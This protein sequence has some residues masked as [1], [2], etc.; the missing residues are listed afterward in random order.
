MRYCLLAILFLFAGCSVSKDGEL[1]EVGDYIPPGEPGYDSAPSDHVVMVRSNEIVSCQGQVVTIGDNTFITA[2]DLGVELEA[3]FRYSHPDEILEIT[4][5][6]DTFDGSPVEL[7]TIAFHVQG[8]N[9]T[10]EVSPL[11]TISKAY[12]DYQQLTNQIQGQ[13][14][15]Y[16]QNSVEAVYNFFGL[17]STSRDYLTYD[18]PV[19]SISND[20]YID[21]INDAFLSLPEYFGFSS[22]GDIQKFIDQ[23]QMDIG[24]DGRFDGF[25][26]DSNL[27]KTQL[28]I[29]GQSS[30]IDAYTYLTDILRVASRNA[31]SFVSDQN[32][33]VEIFNDFSE[34][35]NTRTLL[36][37]NKPLV[38]FDQSAPQ[39]EIVCLPLGDSASILIR[40]SDDVFAY[41]A[42]VSIAGSALQIPKRL[43]SNFYIEIDY[44]E[45]GITIDD[46]NSASVRVTDLA[47]FYLEKQIN[48]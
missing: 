16:F 4:L 31:Y 27:F 42:V 25:S 32:Q 36:T 34:A 26:L 24:S 28:Y 48:P 40:V 44:S 6:C 7:K 10:F 47:G 43:G 2:L 30:P 22:E 35:S 33:F 21:A 37:T 38:E 15:L 5:E 17:E 12:Y 11:T 14:E 45:H 20:L 1:W 41:E 13:E 18:F 9:K 46:I 8:E 19:L 23:V 29:N 39:F 3:Q